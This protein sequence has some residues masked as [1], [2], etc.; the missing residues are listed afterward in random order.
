MRVNI[1]AK[2]KKKLNEERSQGRSPREEIAEGQGRILQKGLRAEESQRLCIANFQD[3]H[4]L[5]FLKE[6]HSL[7]CIYIQASKKQ[8]VRGSRNKS[9]EGFIH[10]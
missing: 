1:K 8:A 6:S 7:N 5:L 10:P 9:S 3:T 4:F 2:K